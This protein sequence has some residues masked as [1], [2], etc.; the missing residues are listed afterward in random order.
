MSESD[1]DLFAEFK[2]LAAGRSST[3]DCSDCPPSM[4]SPEC[5]DSSLINKHSHVV[6]EAIGATV[7]CL[8]DSM[9]LC[10]VLIALG[11][12]HATYDV[13]PHYLSVGECTST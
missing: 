1:K 5:P 4:T 6:M 2:R 10:R 11:Q 12:I 13:R 9:F 3:I 8:D 7:E